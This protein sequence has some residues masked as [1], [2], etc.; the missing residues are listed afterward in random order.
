MGNLD[1]CLNFL[2]ALEDGA[3]GKKSPINVSYDMMNEFLTFYVSI[4]HN[5]RCFINDYVS[6]KLGLLFIS[7]TGKFCKQAME[8]LDEELIKKSILLHIIEGFE[9]DVRENI[10]RLVFSYYASEV[11]G[12]NFKEL[13]SSMYCYANEYVIKQLESFC[14]RD[15]GLNDLRNFGVAVENDKGKVRFRA[16]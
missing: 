12:F 10:R 2:N 3:K 8:L 7:Y 13:C 1:F 9:Y 15:P 6:D 14:N 16:G 5:D 4:S 11:N